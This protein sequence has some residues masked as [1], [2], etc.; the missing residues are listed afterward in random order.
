MTEKEQEIYFAKC[1]EIFRN[2]HNSSTK[3]MN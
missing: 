2:A 3:R 1:D